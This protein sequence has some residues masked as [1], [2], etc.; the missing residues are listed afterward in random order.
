[1]VQLNSNTAR[2]TKPSSGENAKVDIMLWLQFDCQQVY[3]NII[4]RI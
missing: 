3:N 1:M 2:L 4:D